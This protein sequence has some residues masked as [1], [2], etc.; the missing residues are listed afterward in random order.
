MFLEWT[1]EVEALQNDINA[2]VNCQKP[3][4][5]TKLER[6][7]LDN[8]LNELLFQATRVGMMAELTAKGEKWIIEAAG[9]DAI[10]PKK[11]IVTALDTPTDVRVL[12]AANLSG[13]LEISFK[14]VA[15]A[16]YYNVLAMYEDEKEYRILANKT[17]TKV[18]LKGL[19]AKKRI[20]IVIC[21]CGANG[22]MSELSESISII[23]S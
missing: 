1:T 14:S 9:F 22:L 17:T 18:L 21:A 5:M 20:T 11:T 13:A 2:V 16:R 6:T 23:I 12:N 10:D 4:P 15:H 19:I 7:L 3:E 8:A